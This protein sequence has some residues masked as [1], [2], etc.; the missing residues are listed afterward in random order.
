[1]D[2]YCPKCGEPWDLAEFEYEAEDRG[3]SAAEL[4]RR[5]R[6]G[7][8]CRVFDC[9]CGPPLDED[10][11]AVIGLVYDMLGDDVDGAAATLEDFFLS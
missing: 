1:M 10:K 5:F 3:V 6:E 8:G 7:E 11:S 9:E 2:I 4:R